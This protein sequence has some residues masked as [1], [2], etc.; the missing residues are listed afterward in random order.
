MSTFRQIIEKVLTELSM[1][2]GAAAQVYAEPQI[3]QKVQQVYNRLYRE[4][5]WPDLM[6]W[7]T[8]TLDGTTGMV[9]SDVSSVLKYSYDLQLMFIG[10]T[11]QKIPRLP[12]DINPNLLTGTVPDYFEI[13]NDATKVF[14]VLPITS[15]GTITARVRTKQDDFQDSDTVNFDDDLLVYATVVDYAADDGSNSGQI[16][17]YQNYFDDLMRQFRVLYNDDYVPLNAYN[18]SARIPERWR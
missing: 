3:G 13:V 12:P 8:W 1:V 2:A 9:T 17:K 18:G 5:W 11:D 14:R 15:T 16:A 10:G 6:S 4:F 7:Q